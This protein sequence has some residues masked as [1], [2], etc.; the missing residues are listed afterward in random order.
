MCFYLDHFV[1]Q[2]FPHFHQTWIS[3][4]ILEERANVVHTVRQ[5]PHFQN[6]LQLWQK[7]VI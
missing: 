4:Q 2:S 6:A 7:E 3:N 1:I 5:D